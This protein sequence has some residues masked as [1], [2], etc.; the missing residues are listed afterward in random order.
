MAVKS[1][2]RAYI[3]LLIRYAILIGMVIGFRA[4]YGLD[5]RLEFY[6]VLSVVIAIL[7]LVFTF[8]EPRHL[9]KV[10]P[11]GSKVALIVTLT[12][13]FLPL[14]RMKVENIKHTQQMRG[15]KFTGLHQIPN[16][17]SLFIPSI[18]VSMNW[19]DRLCDGL[20]MR[21]EEQ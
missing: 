13:R 1:K 4:L 19:A 14:M 9:E 10:L 20:I 12:L 5:L 21:G 2:V 18:I 3:S 16:Y 7:L 6:A 8:I 17:L 15:A 11:K